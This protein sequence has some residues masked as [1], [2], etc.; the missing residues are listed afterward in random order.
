L[1]DDVPWSTNAERVWAEI[2]LKEGLDVEA[3]IAAV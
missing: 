3:R 1:H 2:M